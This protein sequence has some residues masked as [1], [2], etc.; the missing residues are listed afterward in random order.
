MS[1][2]R[3][4]EGFDL[5]WSE[6]TAVDLKPLEPYDSWKLNLRFQ[7]A[8][9]GAVTAKKF[10]R[11]KDGTFHFYPPTAEQAEAL[12]KTIAINNAPVEASIPSDINSV[13]GIIHHPE[14]PLL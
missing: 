7:W 4:D 8:T 2:I 6:M 12:Y 13:C 14:I 10:R 3:F 11:L 1:V 9:L 5:E